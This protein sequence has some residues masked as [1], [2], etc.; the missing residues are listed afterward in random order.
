MA[1]IWGSVISYI[2]IS[3]FFYYYL[4]RFSLDIR[5]CRFSNCL[6]QSSTDYLIQIETPSRLKW[7]CCY[8]EMLTSLNAASI[9]SELIVSTFWAFAICNAAE[10]MESIILGVPL[11]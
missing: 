3:L 2:A 10:H 6:I 4:Y 11:L 8:N 5:M 9:T 7:R 1:I